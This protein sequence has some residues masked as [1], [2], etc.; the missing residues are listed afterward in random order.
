[1][2][3]NT[4]PSFEFAVEKDAVNAVELD[5]CM[6]ADSG[7]IVW[8]DWDPGDGI[9]KA[10]AE[11][12]EE[13]VRFKPLFPDTGSQYHKP[14]SQLKLQEVLDH[15]GYAA[16]DSA[17]RGKAARATIPTFQEFMAWATGKPQL[18]MIVLDV[19]IP[20]EEA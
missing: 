13:D 12:L 10:R 11:G 19:K 3:E 15:F 9:A 17:D 16:K 8:H 7:I 2:V 20:D 5:L 18:Q 4:I 6:T 14:I 1:E